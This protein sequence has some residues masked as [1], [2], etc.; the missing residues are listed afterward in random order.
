LHHGHTYSIFSCKRTDAAG[1]ELSGSP[2]SAGAS[3]KRS[4]IVQR[5]RDAAGGDAVAPTPGRNRRRRA[6]GSV[7]AAVARSRVAASGSGPTRRGPRPSSAALR[8]PRSPRDRQGSHDGQGA[9]RRAG[10]RCSTC[11]ERRTVP[12]GGGL[13][14]ARFARF[15]SM[16][17]EEPAGFGAESFTRLRSWHSPIRESS[18][19]EP[20]AFQA[21][22][23]ARSIFT[24]AGKT[25]ATLDCVEGII[26][27]ANACA[28]RRVNTIA[29]HTA[30][31]PTRCVISASIIVSPCT[32]IELYL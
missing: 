18:P 28:P 32:N 20:H 3:A 11:R 30:S 24:N 7:A 25:G 16:Q 9:A 19:H 26:Q 22:G 8:E 15:P 13:R 4:S 6:P 12:A 14:A 2:A 29:P 31:I 17:G 21:T 1:R 10:K 27:R 5:Q 23:F